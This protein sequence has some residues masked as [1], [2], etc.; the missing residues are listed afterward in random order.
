MHKW[1]KAPT[2]AYECGAKEQT[3]DHEITYC[4]FYHHQKRARVLSVVPSIKNITFINQHYS[5][6]QLT[7]RAGFELVG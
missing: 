3:A 1:G 2:A 4:P 6:L 5:V 7:L